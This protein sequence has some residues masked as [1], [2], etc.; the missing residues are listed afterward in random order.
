MRIIDKKIFCQYNT[1]NKL[2]NITATKSG[3]RWKAFYFAQMQENTTFAPQPH[4]N[5]HEN[6]YI[7]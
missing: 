3:I 6:K 4:S 2:I 5:N 7:Y 1:E